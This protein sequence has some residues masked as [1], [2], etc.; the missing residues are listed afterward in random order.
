M[1]DTEYPLELLA[2]GVGVMTALIVRDDFADDFFEQQLHEFEGSA[3][4]TA[5]GLANLCRILLDLYT[6]ATGTPQCETL[7]RIGRA[8]ANER[9]KYGVS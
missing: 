9:L 2:R 3:E 5:V 6:R 1:P 7:R 8:T 4:A